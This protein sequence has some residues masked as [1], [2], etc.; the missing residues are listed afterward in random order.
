MSEHLET[1]SGKRERTHTRRRTPIFAYLAILF[2]AAFL[3]L[4]LAY[5]QQQRTNRESTEV[6]KQSAS[7][8]ES[9]QLLMEDN[10][11][12]R[13]QVKELEGQLSEK[14]RELTDALRSAQNNGEK[15]RQSEDAVA[16]MQWFWQIE[17]AYA[18]DKYATTRELIEKFEAT[19]L[20]SALPSE[21]TTGTQRFSPAARYQEIYDAL[22]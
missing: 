1:E 5:Y 20:V 8:V 3:M 11:K 15:T 14:D 16:A 10:D 19:G 18:K 22:F 9:I 21:N 17:S 12:L 6:L 7:A 4:L 13:E 2:A